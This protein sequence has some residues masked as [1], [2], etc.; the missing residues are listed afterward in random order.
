MKKII[1]LLLGVVL[2]VVITVAVTLYAGSMKG[3]WGDFRGIEEAR[4]AIKELPLEIP[5]AIG[6]WVADGERQ[7]DDTSI[8]ML[9][10]QD[11]YIFRSYRNTVTQETVHLTLMAGPSGKMTTHTPET[12]FGG[13]DYE[14]EAARTRVPFNVRLASG[15]EIEDVFWQVDFIGRTMDVNNRISFYWAISTGGPWEA[16]DSPRWEFRTFR[17]VY[18]LQVEAFSGSGEEEDAVRRFLE[19]ALP[20]IHEHLRPCQ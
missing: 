16:R 12:C 15:E 7:L 18:K 11:S 9:Q 2:I 10:I 19:D 5:G 6:T 3:R 14:R 8:R 1:P 13:R 20:T 17:F 4:A